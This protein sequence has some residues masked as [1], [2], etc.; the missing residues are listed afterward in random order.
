VEFLIGH[1]ID[2]V[3]G[4]YDE[5]VANNREHCGCRAEEPLQ[6]EMAHLSFVWTKDHVSL[7]SKDYMKNLPPE[8]A[9][10]VF[11]RRVRLFHATPKKNNLY[12]YEDRPEKF[13]HE[14]AEKVA[15]D[16]MIFGHTHKPYRKEL[17]G[18]IFINAGS[19]GKPKDGDPRACVAIVEITPQTVRTEFLRVP[20]DIE[21]VAS[22]IIE[23]GL[24]PYY[25]ERLRQGK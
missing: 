3:Q 13:F 24:P 25:A 16:I 9:F 11:G 18:K 21:K 15:A 19:V 1:G 4:N 12:W 14:M 22:A 10:D 2:G 5:A 6:E 23:Q 7:K 17:N 8:L 20:Y